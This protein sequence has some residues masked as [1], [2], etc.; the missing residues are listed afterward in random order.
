M[1]SRLLLLLLS[2]VSLVGVY[3]FIARIVVVFV[4][5]VDIGCGGRRQIF[6]VENET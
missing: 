1:L 6:R 3:V 5:S 2:P 4:A